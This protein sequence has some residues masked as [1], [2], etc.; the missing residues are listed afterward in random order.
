MNEGNLGNSLDDSDI[1]RIFCLKILYSR[2]GDYMKRN[3][4]IKEISDGRLIPPEIW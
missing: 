2:E 3:V 1:S 4:D